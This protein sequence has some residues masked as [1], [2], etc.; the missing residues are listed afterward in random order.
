ML[1]L[2]FVPASTMLFHLSTCCRTAWSCQLV[3]LQSSHLPGVL[4]WNNVSEAFDSRTAK[5]GSGQSH[6]CC[7]PGVSR[8]REQLGLAELH[9]VCDG[10]RRFGFHFFLVQFTHTYG[11]GG[12]LPQH[13]SYPLPES[14]NVSW[15]HRALKAVVLAVVWLEMMLLT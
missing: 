5:V 7:G 11:S 2:S 9:R 3:T 4:N 15:W 8:R 12:I 10:H 6:D 13:T 14:S 1:A